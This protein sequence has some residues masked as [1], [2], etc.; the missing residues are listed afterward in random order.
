MQ[1]SNVG[2]IFQALDS[3]EKDQIPYYIKRG[4]HLGFRP[5]AIFDG[6]TGVGVPSNV[7]KLYQF[8][9]RNYEEGAEVYMFGFSRGAFTIRTLISMIESQELIVP[10]LPD[11]NGKEVSLSHDEMQRLSEDAYRAYRDDVSGMAQ[12]VRH[13][14]SLD[15]ERTTFHPLRIEEIEDKPDI[16]RPSSDRIKEVWFAGVHSDV[17]GGYPDILLF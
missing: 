1:E 8:L 11:R 7:R 2:R 10:K 5:W 6:A 3:S 13:A 14:L 17:G 12:V 4:R 9:C 15:D 16:S